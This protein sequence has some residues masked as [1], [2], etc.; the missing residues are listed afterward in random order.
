MPPAI[1]P[2][3]CDLGNVQIH[4]LEAGVGHLVLCLHGF[5]DHAPGMIPLMGVLAD[6]GYRA[7]APFMRGYAPSTVRVDTYE[8]AAL[9]GDALGVANALAAGEDFSLV[10]HD[11]GGQAALHAA[12]LQ[13]DRVR[14]LV[15]L[16][17][18][19]PA[20]MAAALREDPH[21]LRRSWHEFVFLAPGF[22]ERLATADDCAFLADLVRTWSP[23]PP[24][25][26]EE[27][28]AVSRTLS[29]RGVM[30]AALGYFRAR[31]GVAAGDPVLRAS[32]ERAEDPVEA[33]ALVVFGS[34]DGNV[35]AETHRRQGEEH[36]LGEV[37]L[38]EV[39]GAGHWPHRERPDL[40]P[41]AI[42][43]FLRRR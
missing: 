37:R 41:D 42:V 40:V 12:V 36:F 22:A 25:L 14:G 13:S 29:G 30:Q 3:V 35:L 43:E 1:S 24:M 6:A 31:H 11:V 23:V 26:P 17:A 21:Q 38:M 19:H 15:T 2:G 16:G 27:W 4:Y 28:R 7:V 32:A 18:P 39:P 5:P 10:G 9:A 8:S 33:D 20:T 34:D